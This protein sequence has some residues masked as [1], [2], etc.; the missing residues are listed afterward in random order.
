MSLATRKHGNLG[1]VEEA[2]EGEP[3]SPISP[4]PKSSFQSAEEQVPETTIPPENNQS[5]SFV[6]WIESLFSNI[7]GSCGN[8]LMFMQE[9]C[10][11]QQQPIHVPRPAKPPLSIT[12]ELRKLAAKEG[13]VFGG[14]MRR[15]DIPR[16]LGEEAVYSFEDDN[17]SAISQNTLEELTKH[18]IS[19]RKQQSVESDG[20][21]V[22]DP[23]PTHSNSTENSDAKETEREPPEAPPDV[24]QPQ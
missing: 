14:G 24:D 12:D 15:A 18:G 19:F 23:V 4:Q 13:R 9:S 1:G 8:A 17:I 21:P 7:L 6:G 11:V 22:P 5:A 16:F 2:K 20:S 3:I 10:G